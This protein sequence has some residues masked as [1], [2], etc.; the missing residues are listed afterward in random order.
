MKIGEDGIVE[1]KDI[2]SLQ[3]F[4]KNTADKHFPTGCK[5]SH[6]LGRWVDQNTKTPVISNIL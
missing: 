1:M 3:V 4:F 5:G 6:I 2:L